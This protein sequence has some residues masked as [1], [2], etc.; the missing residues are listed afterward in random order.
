MVFKVQ[1]VLNQY[2]LPPFPLSVTS[3]K[4]S[5]VIRGFFYAALAYLATAAMAYMNKYRSFQL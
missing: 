5:P 4:K 2:L 1:P 3:M